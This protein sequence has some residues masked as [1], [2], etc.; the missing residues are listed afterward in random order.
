MP[1]RAVRVYFERHGD[2]RFLSH[3]DFLRV[4]ERAIRRSGIEVEYTAGFNPRV[5]VRMP[6]AVP[7]GVASQ[8]DWF[9]LRVDASI[10]VKEVESRLAAEMPDGLRISRAEEGAAP[11]ASG[12][13][14][15]SIPVK[16]G[17]AAAEAAAT[18]LRECGDVRFSR[19]VAHGACVI[20]EL[21]GDGADGRPPRIRECIE[22]VRERL[23]ARGFSGETDAATKH[24]GDAPVGP[25]DAAG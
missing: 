16:D 25:T 12:S 1:G 14:W 22:R 18:S 5:R 3:L 17:Q 24:S 6:A 9:G 11:P 13:T 2:A 20:L 4:V 23:K 7:V 19:A 21:V 10:P 15:L 8:G